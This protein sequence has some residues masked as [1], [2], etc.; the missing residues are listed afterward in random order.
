MGGGDRNVKEQR[1]LVIN[2]THKHEPAW[3]CLKEHPSISAVIGLKIRID[4]RPDCCGML[5]L[6][7][8]GVVS[9]LPGS[10]FVLN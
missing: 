7:S 4:P 10:R 2:L 5:D 1:T 3:S 9:A 8:K 6:E